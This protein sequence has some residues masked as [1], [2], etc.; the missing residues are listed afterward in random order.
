M[1]GVLFVGAAHPPGIVQCGT[2]RFYGIWWSHCTTCHLFSAFCRRVNSNGRDFMII[3]LR[4]PYELMRKVECA[5]PRG[6]QPFHVSHVDELIGVLSPPCGA[7]MLAPLPA[8]GDS[9][10]L[11][12]LEAFR[13]AYSWV[14]LMVVAAP[15]A[16]ESLEMAASVGRLGALLVDIGRSG[17]HERLQQVAFA[18]HRETLSAMVWSHANLRL[19][20]AAETLFRV[21]LRLAHEPC[22]VPQLAM[23]SGMSERGMRKYCER[24]GIPNPQRIIVWARVLLATYLLDRSGGKPREVARQLGFLTVDNLRTMM[25]RH[26]CSFSRPM[27]SGTRMAFV[28]SA[29]QEYFDQ[30]VAADASMTFSPAQWPIENG[31]GRLEN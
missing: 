2:R 20:G 4:M 3:A 5:F 14:P 18:A 16:F 21:A 29:I 19:S 13:R 6:S 30:P 8:M 15:A 25:W 22:S 23:A 24:W 1:D 12:Q 7:L 17:W 11:G 31:N 28:V 10:L 27:E 9:G 26:G